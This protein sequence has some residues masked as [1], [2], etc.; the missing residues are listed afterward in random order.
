MSKGFRWLSAVAAIVLLFAIAIGCAIA[1]AW[2]ALPLDQATI[3]IDGETVSVPSMVG[4]HAAL[5]LTMVVLAVLMAGILAAGGVA[6]A[7]AATVLGLAV[8]AIA[9]IVSMLLAASPVLVVG[10]LIWRLARGPLQPARANV[11]ASA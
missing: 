4:W 9:V 2:S 8:A 5:V 10:W 6:I 1:A 7:I 3:I 11:V